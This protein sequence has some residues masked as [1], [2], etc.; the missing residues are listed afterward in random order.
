MFTTS[1]QTGMGVHNRPLGG[2]IVVSE[3]RTGPFWSDN[4]GWSAQLLRLTALAGRGGAEAT[5]VATAVSELKSGDGDGWYAALKGLAEGLEAQL[6]GL[7]RVPPAA[8]RD[9]L[10]RASMYH[11]YSVAFLLPSEP[12][13]VSALQARR[14]TFQGAA[15]LH[16]DPIEQVEIPYEDGTLP[17]YLCRP[18]GRSEGAF[19]VVVVLGGTDGAAEEMWFAL[20]RSLTERGYGVLLFDGP[21]QGEARRRGVVARPDFE[22]AV[23]AAVDLLTAHPEVASGRI[24]LVGHSLGGLYAARAAARDPRL[25][26]LV[27][28]SAPFDVGAALADRAARPGPDPV[29]EFMGALYADVTGTATVGEALAIL[30]GFHLRDLAPEITVPLL[31]VYGAD[32]PLVPLSEG[33]RLIE[34]VRSSEKELLV[35]GSGAPGSAHCQQDAPV[36]AEFPVG[37]WLARHV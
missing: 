18:S 23:S 11:R 1:N 30:R 8:A 35:Y 9:L 36:V 10:W 4:P 37:N 26:A 15:Q 20:G 22:L 32:D 28:C 6:V 14:R 7:S 5:E 21:G 33:E 2:V 13:A 31:A 27:V 12:R 25:R 3:V 29:L 34:A 16:S 19:P 24:G 17:G